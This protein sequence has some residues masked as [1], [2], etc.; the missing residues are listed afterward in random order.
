MSVKKSSTLIGQLATV[1]I[2][3]TKV[4]RIYGPWAVV[5][6]TPICRSV[7]VWVWYLI[8]SECSGSII[9]KSRFYEWYCTF[10]SFYW[11]W[12][13]SHHWMNGAF[14]CISRLQ[15]LHPWQNSEVVSSES[16]VTAC[17]GDIEGVKECWCGC[18]SFLI[19]FSTQ[20]LRKG[21]RCYRHL[22]LYIW[23]THSWFSINL[24]SNPVQNN[25]NLCIFFK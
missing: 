3:L 24:R 6:N 15:K 25:V 17:K 14:F 22:V 9:E 12:L 7:L 21:K 8:I 16:R 13:K 2:R 10:P 23:K 4:K 20:V 1:H 19:L 11:N 5:K 18:N